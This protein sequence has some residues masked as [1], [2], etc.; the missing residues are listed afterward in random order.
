MFVIETSDVNQ[1]VGVLDFE[2]S[3][4]RIFLFCLSVNT[5]S[6]P[7][8]SRESRFSIRPAVS[9]DVIQNDSK[10]VNEKK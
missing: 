5:V 1:N 3:E 4:E 6:Y 7:V 9:R 10:I 2:W 8:A